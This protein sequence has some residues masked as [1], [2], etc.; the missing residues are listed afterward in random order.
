MEYTDSEKAATTNEARAVQQQMALFRISEQLHQFRRLDDLLEYIAREVQQLLNVGG[1]MVILLDE[2]AQEFFFRVATLDNSESGRKMREIRFPADKGVAGHVFRTGEPL[3]VPDT[4]QNP[5]FFQKVDQDADYQTRNMLDVPIETP[6]HRIGVLCVVNKK[7]GGFEQEHV[8]LLSTVANTIAFPIENARI[9]EQLKHSYEEVKRLNQAKDRIIHHLSHE[10]KTPVS[11]LSASLGILAKRLADVDD[12]SYK[13]ILDRAERNLQRILD[14]QYEI[15]DLLREKEYTTYHLLSILLDACV[16][17]LD[18]L[19]ADELG[20][21]NVMQRVRRR[22]EELFGPQEAISRKIQLD[23]FVQSRVDGLRA[24]FAQRRCQFRVQ[25]EPTPPVLIPPDVLAKLVEG[26][27]RNAVE[28]TPDGS[29]IVVTLRNAPEGPELEVQDFGVGMT[30]ENQQLIVKNY[31]PYYETAQYAS[32]KPYDFNAGGRGF[33]LLRMKI[34][35]ERYHFQ[36]RI[37]SQR[38]RYVPREDDVC[39]G[40]VAQCKLCQSVQDCLD[41][42]GTTIV[43]QFRAADQVVRHSQQSMRTRPVPSEAE[44]K[45]HV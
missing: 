38:C 10:L 43:V 26:L 7:K 45:E 21:W 2:D 28:N 17:E 8:E 40:D 37:T 29:K 27:V 25:T 14:M 44:G 24:R 42:G 1:A 18:V 13:R 6:E 32:R 4:S 31:F 35:A 20:E 19:I 34:F 39:P 5:Y 33:D 11:V 23:R 3:I 12:Q 30:A 16:D 15:E 22:V 36:L 9:N 41:S